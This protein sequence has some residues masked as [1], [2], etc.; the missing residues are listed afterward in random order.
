MKKVTLKMP[1]TVFKGTGNSL[2][3]IWFQ[4]RN[5]LMQGVSLYV[6]IVKNVQTH[7]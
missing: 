3:D 1:H 5:R 7:K 4:I 2:E 6:D